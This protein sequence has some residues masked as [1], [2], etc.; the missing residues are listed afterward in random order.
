MPFTG[1]PGR[2]RQR[3]RS[4]QS[5]APR[6]ATGHGYAASPCRAAGRNQDGD[7][8]RPASRSR[9]WNRRTAKSSAITT[10]AQLGPMRLDEPAVRVADEGELRRK[11]GDQNGG[12]IEQG[13]AEGRGSGPETNVQ[14]AGER[15]G[16]NSE[17]DGA[18][19]D[20]G[21]GAPLGRRAGAAWAGRA[22]REAGCCGRERLQPAEAQ[23]QQK[24]EEGARRSAQTHRR[25]G[26]GC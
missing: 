26:S 22:S 12:E 11:R 19:A 5:A 1:K 10:V 3:L 24:E 21:A 8:G 2:G 18:P 16:H 13:E 6:R 23:D 7:A 14:G 25:A 15:H 17:Q 4:T 9:H 20:G